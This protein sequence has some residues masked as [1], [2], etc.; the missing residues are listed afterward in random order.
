[1]HFEKMNFTEYA[2][3]TAVVLFLMIEEIIA[4][5]TCSKRKL[6]NYKML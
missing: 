4:N 6:I 1:M 5:D 3:M 2:I